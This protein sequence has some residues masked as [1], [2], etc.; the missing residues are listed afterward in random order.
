MQFDAERVAAELIRALRGGRSQVAFSRRL[1]YRSN[2]VAAWEAGRRWPT[3]ADTL[4]AANRIGIDLEAGLRRFYG[5]PVP[6]LDALHPASPEAVTAFLQDSRRER[7]AAELAE[8]SGFSR[9]Q[10][11]RW[12][13]GA[14]QPRL[15]EH[16]VLV[17]ATTQRL[18]DWLAILVDP[19][20]LPSVAAAWRQ[21]E[22]ARTLFW[23]MP[24]A[25]LVL[26][27]LTLES[28]RALP[29][30]DDAW[31]AEALDLELYQVVGAVEALLAT[32]RRARTWCS[33]G[34][35]P[36]TRGASRR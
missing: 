9:H 3:A 33:G 28:Y 36:S 29:A 27:A 30:H 13:R 31:L 15:P 25:Q 10:I 1:G 2:V 4:A 18:L 23:R 19:S 35:R 21:L 17:E 14:A 8:A 11:S 32:A 12:F 20:E 34:C 16:L 24:H 26:L 5:V 22:S 6:F 7:T